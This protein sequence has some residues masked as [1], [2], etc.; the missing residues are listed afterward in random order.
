[1]EV[2]SLSLLVA[3][4]YRAAKIWTETGGYEALRALAGFSSLDRCLS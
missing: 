2:N 1:V 3:V 4:L